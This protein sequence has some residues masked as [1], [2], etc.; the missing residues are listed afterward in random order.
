MDLAQ[1]DKSPF[2]I[3]KEVPSTHARQEPED[4]HNDGPVDADGSAGEK[5]QSSWNDERFRV[6]LAETVQTPVSCTGIGTKKQD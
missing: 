6:K 2:Q 5:L 4:D 3:Q 1:F